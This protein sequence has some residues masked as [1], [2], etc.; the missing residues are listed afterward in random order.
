MVPSVVV[1]A[2]D[3]ESVPVPLQP[4]ATWYVD[5]NLIV[6]E[7]DSVC[8]PPLESGSAR[9]KLCSESKLD[10]SLAV[11]RGLA[12]NGLK[13]FKWKDGLTV[14]DPTFQAVAG[15]APPILKWSGQEMGVVRVWL[16]RCIC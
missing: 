11:W 16:L 2:D 7:E 4:E 9:E 6:E 1:L 13:G 12:D 14:M 8:L 3:S 15:A 5:S 10:K